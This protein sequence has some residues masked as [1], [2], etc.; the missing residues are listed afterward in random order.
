MTFDPTT[1]IPPHKQ[2]VADSSVVITGQCELE[3][4]FTTGFECVGQL[5]LTFFENY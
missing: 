4:F 1:Q 5:S 3:Q 2:E